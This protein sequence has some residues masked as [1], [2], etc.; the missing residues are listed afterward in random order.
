MATLVAEEG[1]KA[2]KPKA[3]PAGKEAAR[4]RP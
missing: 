4:A 1:K 3:K 2:A